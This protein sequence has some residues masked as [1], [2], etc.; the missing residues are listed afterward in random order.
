[1]AAVGRLKLEHLIGVLAAVLVL[2]AA[3]AGFNVQQRF[4]NLFSG[5]GVRWI[6]F[7]IGIATLILLARVISGK[8]R[9]HRSWHYFLAAWV[10]GQA[11]IVGLAQTLPTAPTLETLQA[12]DIRSLDP[13]ALAAVQW[14]AAWSIIVLLAFVFAGA[15]FS[16]GWGIVIWLL[17]VISSLTLV[18]TL[19]EDSL[20]PLILLPIAGIWAAIVF[21]GSVYGVPSGDVTTTA[22]TSGRGVNRAVWASLALVMLGL[23][24]A[25]FESFV[26]LDQQVNA[27]RTVTQRAM[28]GVASG[29]DKV[30]QNL[31]SAA[32]A[33]RTHGDVKGSIETLETSITD[34][35]DQV[36]LAGEAQLLSA[37]LPRAGQDGIA[38]QRVQKADET[39][40]G[41]LLPLGDI[42]PDT[43][44]DQL[45]NLLSRD[46]PRAVATMRRETH[47]AQ[48]VLVGNEL[49]TAGVF[50]WVAAIYAALVLLPWVLF[51]LFLLQKRES[52]AR[53]SLIDLC[54]LDGRPAPDRHSAAPFGAIQPGSLL[55]RVLGDGIQ[56][57]PV[58]PSG[59]QQQPVQ[60]GASLTVG[61]VQSA[62]VERAFSE[63]EY[64]IG[65]A[66][67]SGVVAAGWYM[68]FY[69]KGG[70]GLAD[71]ITQGADAAHLWAYLLSGL[72]PLTAAFT[73]AY[74]W[75]VYALVRRYLDSDLYPAAF[76]QCAVQFVLALVLSLM[77][78]IGFPPL[79]ELAANAINLVGQTAAG[80]GNHLAGPVPGAAL[81]QA[82]ASAQSAAAPVSGPVPPTTVEAITMLL[83]F[84]GGLSISAGFTQV[85]SVLRVLLKFIG[86]R[87]DQPL[88]DQA[89]VTELEGID[90][91]TE[92]RLAEEG[93]DNVQAL[94]SAPLQRLVLRTH[95]TTPRLVD[96]VDQALLYI[97]TANW[98]VQ[99]MD[100]TIT[101]VDTAQVP[102]NADE[103]SLAQDGR[104]DLFRALRYAGV[105]TATDLLGAGGWLKMA[106]SV[107]LGDALARQ[108]TLQ[109]ALGRT[110]L[111][112]DAVFAAAVF[113]ACQAMIESANWV[114]VANYRHATR[115]LLGDE[116]RN[117][118]QTV[119]PPEPAAALGLDGTNGTVAT[120]GQTPPARV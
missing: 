77:I 57:R 8:D 47:L 84:V 23:S 50:V 74:F 9:A 40:Q 91:W 83:A 18:S 30:D 95:F 86:L 28:D 29:V 17:G 117:W 2:L 49:P 44:R 36:A 72:N 110:L 34:V 118:I 56:Q 75:C 89:R 120:A 119:N 68:V 61:Q 78:A 3:L 46:V 10:V 63:P 64:L 116:T 16:L 45:T 104:S 27:D 5:D 21:I 98:P 99:Q 70:V 32:K 51:V 1:M 22:S 69:P 114:H 101:A 13:F 107:D 94:A 19:P 55:D 106:A 73:G 111:G 11:M 52:R 105:R 76:L 39:L 4:D 62:L 35:G 93:I 33:A 37:G 48:Q 109:Q 90:S 100:G 25:E 97:H 60:N 66:V 92:A 26:T 41:L 20:P 67:L 7:L 96:W 54:L 43:D 81:S 112:S 88:M 108:R 24:L 42:N 102:K 31:T 14:G 115:E 6:V 113:T 103:A 12:L 53:E 38:V 87:S 85:L 65:L 58:Q 59:D 79:A 82:A 80:I 71:T 15:R